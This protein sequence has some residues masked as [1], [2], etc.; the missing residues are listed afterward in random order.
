MSV[1]MKLIQNRILGRMLRSS[2]WDSNTNATIAIIK[3][4]Q[5]KVVTHMLKS[6]IW[7]SSTDVKN[8]KGERGNLQ[9]L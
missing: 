3:L 9:N 6:S 8:V 2:I 7:E 4:F 5:E 1:S